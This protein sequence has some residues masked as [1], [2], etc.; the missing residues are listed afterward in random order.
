MK[1]PA[2]EPAVNEE[3]GSIQT[4]TP[5]QLTQLQEKAAKA[6]ELRD[7][8]LRT[9]ADMDNLRKRAVREKQDAIRYANEVMLEKL[10]PVLDNFEMAML[11]TANAE[12]ASVDAVKTGVTMILGQFKNV[13]ADAGLEEIDASGKPF[14]PNIH[15]AV[16]QQESAEVPEGQVL[17]QLR[18]GYKLKDRLLRP[19]TV[20][21][22]KKA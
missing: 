22:S 10:V 12:G 4:L 2:A 13:L 21:V 8:L 6:D 5:E 15:E 18:K 1:Q 14:D 3:T 11:A 19:A 17:Q 16:S 7:Q 9:V 20:V